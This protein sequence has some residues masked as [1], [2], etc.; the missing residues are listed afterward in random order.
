M[1][2]RKYTHFIAKE[3]LVTPVIVV[4]GTPS[5]TV[6]RDWIAE[7][8]DAADAKWEGYFEAKSP[9]DRSAE[10]IPDGE[11]D[12]ILEADIDHTACLKR[13]GGITRL[14]VD[15]KPREKPIGEKHLADCRRRADISFERS[16]QL[17]AR[18]LTNL[19][20][21]PGSCDKLYPGLVKPFDPYFYTY[22]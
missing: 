9:A 1:F 17:V 6:W 3:G 5:R 16:R 14:V 20:A 11:L 2:Y 15:G 8:L 12:R 18:L 4:G 19:G 21:A 13:I 22:W 10:A 7:D